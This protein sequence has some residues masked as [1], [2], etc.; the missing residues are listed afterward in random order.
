MAG[1]KKTSEPVTPQPVIQPQTPDPARAAR[2]GMSNQMAA[3]AT[4][5]EEAKKKQ[6]QAAGMD[7]S[8]GDYTG[9]GALLTG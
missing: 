5:E 8:L 1:S 9:A 7:R 3:S 4:A 6:V 2:A